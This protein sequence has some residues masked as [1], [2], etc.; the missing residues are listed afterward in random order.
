MTYATKGTPSMAASSGSLANCRSSNAMVPYKCSLPASLGTGQ[1]RLEGLTRNNGT[2][3]IPYKGPSLQRSYDKPETSITRAKPYQVRDIPSRLPQRYDSKPNNNNNN[4]SP[5]TY[6]KKPEEKQDSLSPIKPKT[7]QNYF[8]TSKPASYDATTPEQALAKA[9][10]GNPNYLP[11]V[12]PATKQN[13]YQTPKSKSS[14]YEKKPRKQNQPSQLENI[15]QS[16]YS[17]DDVEGLLDGQEL[18]PATTSTSYNPQGMG[19]IEVIIALQGQMQTSFSLTY[20]STRSANGDITETLNIQYSANMNIAQQR[21][22]IIGTFTNALMDYDNLLDDDQEKQRQRDM[23]QLELNQLAENP[24]QRIVDFNAND[25]IKSKTR[26]IGD[27]KE[28]MNY[29]KETFKLTT[30]KD[31]PKDFSLSLVDKK[32]LKQSHDFFN[33]KWQEGIEGFCINR[34]GFGES[35]IFVKKNELAKVMLTIG[36][37]IGHLQSASLNG[38][39]EEAKA[40]AFSIE[41]MN[42]IKEH[43]IA[44]LKNAIVTERPAKNG[45]HNVAFNFVTKLM[46]QGMSAMNVFKE[47]TNGLKHS[48]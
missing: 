48:S 6:D 12:K 20:S 19:N 23:M 35:R 9:Y 30:G 25:F 17:P 32:E 45:L 4:N 26:F 33:G 41:W 11:K 36:H 1:S 46:Q 16:Y 13:K 31:L 27:A 43:N 40:F 10:N 18:L 8:P 28:I 29:V 44:G 22:E 38:I 7:K 24:H 34:K 5:T 39:E 14:N 37:E 42:K 15:S 3:L 47:L 2:N 21:R